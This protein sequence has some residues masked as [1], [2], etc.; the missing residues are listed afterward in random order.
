LCCA[1][2]D[3]ETP[4]DECPVCEA[5]SSQKG[6]DM[7]KLA[8]PS[9]RWVVGTFAQK[10]RGEGPAGLIQLLPTIPPD[11]NGQILPVTEPA[12]CVIVVECHVTCTSHRP[13]TPPPRCS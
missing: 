3:K 1:T 12:G 6:H 9:V 4:A 13:P 10:C 2:A 11:P 5:R 7:P 8:Q